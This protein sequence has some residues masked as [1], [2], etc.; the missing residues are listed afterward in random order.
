VINQLYVHPAVAYA[1]GAVEQPDVMVRTMDEFSWGP[2]L[3]EDFR[4]RINLV[5][6]H[7]VLP[8]GWPYQDN[9]TPPEQP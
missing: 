6:Q 2:L 5:L 3:H 8:P 7:E 9:G 4:Q 1:E